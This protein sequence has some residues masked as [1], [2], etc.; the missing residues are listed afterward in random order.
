[1]LLL[2][3]ETGQG[4]FLKVCRGWDLH[5]LLLEQGWEPLVFF[6]VFFF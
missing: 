4:V 6:F 1:M 5:G 3:F 2:T